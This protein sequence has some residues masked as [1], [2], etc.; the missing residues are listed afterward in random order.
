VEKPFASYALTANGEPLASNQ[1]SST[2]RQRLKHP[3]AAEEH[4]SGQ[5]L[6]CTILVWDE[7]GRQKSR[8]K[9]K[10]KDNERK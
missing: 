5:K 1:K 2:Y 6:R 8:K 4:E 9:R 3:L 10:N 7:K